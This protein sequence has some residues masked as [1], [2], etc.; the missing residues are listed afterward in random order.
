MRG[1]KF[2]SGRDSQIAIEFILIV[3]IVLLIVVAVTPTIIKQQELNKAVSAARDGATFGASMRGMGFHGDVNEAPEGIVK[4]EKLLLEEQPP[5]DGKTWYQ[6]RFQVS[7]PEYMKESSTCTQTTVGS[8]I[9]NQA[10]RY[11]NYTFTGTWQSGTVSKVYTD[12]FKF[13]A[14]CDFV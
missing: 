12:R 11:I 13:T 10:L 4:I 3:G 5:E 9:T 2:Y 1:K 6:I 8:T 7:M 14:A